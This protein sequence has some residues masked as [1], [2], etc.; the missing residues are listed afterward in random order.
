MKKALFSIAI[1][2][3][4]LTSCTTVKSTASV[5]DVDKNVDAQTLTDLQVSGERISYTLR[6]VKSVRRGGL[7]NVKSTAVSEALKANGKGDVLVAPNFE[8]KTRRGLLGTKIK[9][10][11]VTGYVG[12]Y[13]NFRPAAPGAPCHK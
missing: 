1:A 12:T 7:R 8:V 13:K 5:M 9:S 3:L 11:T 4:A 2:A 10:V 6:P